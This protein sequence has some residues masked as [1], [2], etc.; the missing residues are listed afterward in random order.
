MD[1]DN[2]TLKKWQIVCTYDYIWNQRTCNINS[3]MYFYYT[4]YDFTFHSSVIFITLLF[5][6]TWA[7]HISYS[8]ELW[9]GYGIQYTWI[10]ESVWEY[11]QR[12]I[13]M[14]FWTLKYFVLNMIQRFQNSGSKNV[15]AT[16]VCVE[17]RSSK[18]LSH[19]SHGY[20]VKWNLGP[21]SI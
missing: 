9:L 13:A 19:L 5:Q 3:N 2:S 21:V 4:L 6:P 12:K 15:I 17:W 14:P 11:V 10:M 7:I 18:H 16:S 20:G 1:T 8:S